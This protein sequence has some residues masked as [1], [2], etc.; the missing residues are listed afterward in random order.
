MRFA[1]IDIGT[2]TTRMLIAKV[3]GC[4]VIPLAREYAITNL[5][6]GV[7]TTHHLRADAIARVM[8]ALDR[9]LQVRSDLSPAD[10]PVRSTIVMA[11]SAARDADNADEFVAALAERGLSLQVIPG[12]KE[13]ALSFQGASLGF[14]GQRIMVVDVGGGSTE[15]SVGIG[16]EKPQFSHSFDIGC[17]RITERFFHSDPPTP[18]QLSLAKVCIAEGFDPWAERVRTACPPETMITVAGTATSAVSMRDAMEVY[19]SDVVHGSTVTARDMDELIERLS[20]M[21]LAQREHII[22]LDPGRAP[23]IV[24][25]LMIL[26]HVMTAFKMHH[27]V[28]SESDLLQGMI[29]LSSADHA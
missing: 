7:D 17:R 16:G 10:D 27:F 1:A 20:A 24:A 18:D 2:V 5:G 9:F 22:G 28:V 13:A 8:D 12:S 25:G 26:C 6:E 15:I 21:T 23:V 19:D 29:L 4:R 3:E 11:T 14:E